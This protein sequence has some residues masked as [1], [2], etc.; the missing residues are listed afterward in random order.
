MKINIEKNIYNIEL[1][2]LIT[3]GKRVNNSLRNFLFISKVLGKHIEVRGDICK[4]IGILLA[5]AMYENNNSNDINMLLEYLKNPEK[6][7]EHTK[8]IIDS[9]TFEN[10]G[11]DILILGFAET[12]TGL[13]MAVAS[14]IE[15]SFY[16]TTT[17]ED[18]N[19]IEPLVNFLEEHSHAT[20]HKCFPLEKKNIINKDRI[21]LVDDEITTGK[22]MINIIKELTKVTNVKK[23][24]VLSILD[25]RSYEHKKLFEDMESETEIKANVVSLISGNIKVS[26]NRVFTNNNENE[27]T[28]KTEVINLNGLDRIS[29]VSTE[30]VKKS[31]YKDSGR[32]GTSRD[33]IV[34]LDFMCSSIAREIEKYINSDWKI[35]VMGHGE[36]I[37]IPAKISSYLKNDT[38]FKTTTRS[39]IFCDKEEGYP[40]K[41]NNIFYD[42][43]VK[44]Y[45]YNKEEIESKYDKVILITEND[46][47]IKLTENILIFKI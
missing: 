25:W 45:M 41:S 26:D 27:I 4:G 7:N 23:Y 12:A 13:G 40:I 32:F 30:N 28:N 21:I 18:I 2:S 6:I 1:D 36:N 3:V 46:L 35:L 42:E 43:G 16:L 8:S 47:N 15:N 39:P 11:E 29:V 14:S 34:K 31:Y 44:Y 22:S 24:T 37:Y 10:K 5:S 20:V 17:R 9:Y 38:Y 33:S 19:S